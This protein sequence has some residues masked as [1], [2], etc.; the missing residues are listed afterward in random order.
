MAGQAMAQ[1]TEMV[2][3]TSDWA[4]Q[5]LQAAQDALSNLGAIELSQSYPYYVGS[6]D[7]PDVDLN[8]EA[9]QAGAMA[10]GTAPD[11]VPLTL[12]I[13][14]PVKPTYATPVLGAMLDITLPDVP[15]VNFPTMDITPPVY[16]IPA[17]KQW[18]FDINNILISDDPLVMECV[19]RLTNNI[20]YGGTGLTPAIED[21][22]WNRDLERNEQT[23]QDSTDK[24][25]QAWAKMGFS[26][27]DGMLAHSLAELQKEYENR[28]IDRSREIAIKQAELEQVNL[29]KSIELASGL[30]AHI[31]GLE[32][33]YEKLVLEAQNL[34]AKYANEYIDMQIKAYIAQVDAYKARSQVYEMLIRAELAK[35]EVY[36]T[37]IEGQKLIGEVNEQTVK[38]YAEKHRA[39]AI[40]IDAYKSEIQAMTAELE[41]EKTKIEA[42][43]L[44]FDAWAKKA[45]VAI[46]KYNGEIEMYKANSS[47]NISKAELMSKQAEAEARINL[48]Y[49]ELKV[50]SLEANNRE[51]DLKAQI[52][53]GALKGVADAY[54]SMAA[55]AMAAISAR[56]SMSY[57]ETAQ[58][59]AGT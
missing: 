20:R 27:P 22:I 7:L 46:A 43:K 31:I 45:D 36:K 56:A 40:L 6:V 24:A 14:R 15:T 3:Q 55:G 58:I 29:F 23:L 28:R 37:Q 26:L 48:A 11:I 1:V 12:P 4:S 57:E 10:I 32:I 13:T 44:Q 18:N 25:V 39:I 17:P 21:A 5:L 8:I 47:V 33:E 34:T 50:K 53:M 38:I 49:V 59:G 41:M 2:N 9:A 35:V 19:S 51:M 52:T 42:N 30:M 16:N 54:S